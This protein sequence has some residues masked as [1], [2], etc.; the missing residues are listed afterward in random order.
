MK[1]TEKIEKL[2]EKVWGMGYTEDDSPLCDWINDNYK[3]EGQTIENDF[4]MVQYNFYEGGY[5]C[6]LGKD[7]QDIGGIYCQAT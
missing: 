4:P 7:E 3:E 1:R 6:T 2:I 5:E